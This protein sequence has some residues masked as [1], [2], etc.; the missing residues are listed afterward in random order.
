MQI[1]IYYLSIFLQYYVITDYY[2]PWIIVNQGRFDG[3]GVG[4]TPPLLINRHLL[5]RF[6]HIFFYIY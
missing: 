2:S 6:I 3:R 1:N 4:L 5:F